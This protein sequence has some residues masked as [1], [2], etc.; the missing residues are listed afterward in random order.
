MD[1]QAA[2]FG[3]EE[4]VRYLLNLVTYLPLGSATARAVD[5]SSEWSTGEHILA[6]V[7][8]QVSE[9]NLLLLKAHFELK[10]AAPE[11]LH[12]PRPGD[13]PPPP[14]PSEE[15]ITTMNDWR[16]AMLGHD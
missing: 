11:P 4:S 13:P 9:T 5:P 2:V 10:G 15:L 3:E 12:I 7:A 6:L 16:R 8:E 14:P 1:L